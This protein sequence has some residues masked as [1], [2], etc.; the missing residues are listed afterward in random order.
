[1]AIANDIHQNTRY[2]VKTESELHSETINKMIDLGFYTHDGSISTLFANIINKNIS[3]LYSNVVEL[4]LNCF[5]STAT[6]SHLDD[7]AIKKG[8]IRGE[9]ETDE[10]LRYRISN[11]DAFNSGCNFYSIRQHIL[12]NYQSVYDVKLKNFSQGAGSCTLYIYSN[13][14]NEKE[15]NSIQLTAAEK[16][17]FGIIT[18]VVYPTKNIIKFKIKIVT[19]KKTDT[20][21]IDIKR[22]ITKNLKELFVSTGN[23]D[24][25]TYNDVINVIEQTDKS[26]TKATILESYLN[27]EL[28][29][30]KKIINSD[31]EIYV[32]S[33]K[34]EILI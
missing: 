15:L 11:A 18:R 13:N 3:D 30:F 20:E 31:N 23:D 2:F 7:M 8:L 17:P 16:I 26:I 10:S 19:T 12:N 28:F 34:S 25:I 14:E 6:G 1:M 22:N 21:K 5:L 32:L 29:S 24:V 27:D 9:E 33:D 4:H